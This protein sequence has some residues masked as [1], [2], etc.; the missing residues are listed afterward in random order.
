MAKGGDSKQ[1]LIITLV[2]FVLL[3]VLLGVVAYFGYAEQG[4]MDADRKK[5]VEDKKSIESDRDWHSFTSLVARAYIGNFPDKDLEELGVMLEKNAPPADDGGKKRRKVG[6]AVKAKVKDKEDTDKLLR[7]LE[8]R[9][10]NQQL[11]PKKPSSN[12]EDELKKLTAQIGALE[13]AVKDEQLKVARLETEKKAKID[14]L[15]GHKKAAEAKFTEQKQEG[16][17]NL[18]G[19][20]NQIDGQ[21]K[22]LDADGQLREKLQESLGALQEKYDKTIKAKD[23]E[24]EQLNRRMQKIEEKIPK[25]N[26]LEYDYPKGKI[27]QIDRS[28]QLPFIDLGRAD[29]VKPQLTFSIHGVGLD[30]KPQ[31]EPKGSL[32]VL[33]VLGERISQGRITYVK[34]PNRDPVMKGDVLFNPVWSPTLKQHVAIAGLVDLAGDGRR[35]NPAQAMRALMDFIRTLESQGVVVDAYL[36]LR[37][38]AV[39]GELSRQTDYLILGETPQ[40]DPA[41]FKD[42]DPKMQRRTTVANQMAEMQKEAARNGVTLIPLRRFLALSG[43][44]PPRPVSTTQEDAGF[45]RTNPSVPTPLDRRGPLPGADD[46]PPPIAPPGNKPPALPG[47]KGPGMEK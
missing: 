18:T 40:F 41:G 32:E 30:G 39:K 24:I 4:R 20:V 21:Q 36:D 45:R 19:F 12:Y 44:R 14:E 9:F 29:N 26:V 3:S 23:K 34:D 2:F 31:K 6:S 33:E 25:L 27:I 11:L 7:L 38:L 17:K 8:N 28:G 16:V 37:E 10:E 46:K 15:E 5:A 35:D 43:I 42:E 13:G 47:G 1:G 22:Q